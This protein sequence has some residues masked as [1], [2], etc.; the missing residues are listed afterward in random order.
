MCKV[1]VGRSLQNK[2]QPLTFKGETYFE[3]TYPHRPYT[4]F[5]AIKMIP[6]RLNVI[7]FGYTQDGPQFKRPY[8]RYPFFIPVIVLSIPKTYHIE[9]LRNHFNGQKKHVQG[10]YG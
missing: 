5:L 2:F 1:D 7:C 8:H 10:R 9:P 3:V 6:Q 4:C